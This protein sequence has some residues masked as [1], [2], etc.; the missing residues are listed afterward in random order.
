MPTRSADENQ[1][2][3]VD[4]DWLRRERWVE[5]RIDELLADGVEIVA[6]ADQAEAEWL[7]RPEPRGLLTASRY[8]ELITPSII[9]APW[10]IPPNTFEELAVLIISRRRARL[11]GMRRLVHYLNIQIKLVALGL[12]D[13]WQRDDVI[14]IV[15]WT[16]ELA[17]VPSG[18]VY[19]V[20]TEL[21]DGSIG[22]DL[23]VKP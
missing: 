12:T 6:A 11:R 23:R 15:R 16:K 17:R 8:I 5:R 21:A 18:R 14:P 3:I 22:Y 4:A 10:L 13:P 2:D 1:Q 20:P 7:A 19:A 9:K